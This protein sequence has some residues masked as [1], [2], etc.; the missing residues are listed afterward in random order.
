MGQLVPGLDVDAS[1]GPSPEGWEGGGLVCAHI[2][3]DRTLQ[4]GP[5]QRAGKGFMRERGM[6]AGGLASTG[7]S[8]EGWEGGSPL[9]DH[10]RVGLG[11]STGPSP[12]GWEGDGPC[13]RARS[14]FNPLQRGPAQRAGKG[15]SLI[16]PVTDELREKDRERWYLAAARWASSSLCRYSDSSDIHLSTITASGPWGSGRAGPLALVVKEQRR[17]P[18]GEHQPAIRLPAPSAL[19][20]SQANLRWSFASCA[21]RLRGPEG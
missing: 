5:A 16:E 3:G 15:A 9:L 19:G 11:A 14:W 21:W 20:E 13:R 10:D 1:T 8:P 4:R 18:F 6:G 7:P 17:S 2:D 12:E